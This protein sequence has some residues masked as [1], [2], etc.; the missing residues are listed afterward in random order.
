LPTT[1]GAH[2]HPH[3]RAGDPPPEP[4]VGAAQGP[5]MTDEEAKRSTRG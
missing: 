4:G 3:P 1:S 5:P 2:D